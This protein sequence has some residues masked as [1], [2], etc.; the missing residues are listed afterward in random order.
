MTPPRALAAAAALAVL[1]VCAALSPSPARAE[2]ADA[3]GAAP[4]CPCPGGANAGRCLGSYATCEEACGLT[5]RGGAG[6]GG[7]AGFTPQQQMLLNGMQ[8]M[9]P[10]IQQGIHNAIYGDPAAK[11]REEAERRAREAQERRVREENERRFAEK[12]ARVLGQMD[13]GSGSLAFKDDDEPASS[14][15]APAGKLAFKDDDAPAAPAKDAK[16]RSQEFQKGYDA[17]SRCGSQNAGPACAGVSAAQT[18]KCVSDYRAGYDVGAKELK[19]ALDRAARKGAEAAG[20]GRPNGAASEPEADGDCRTQWV[21][22][23]NRAYFQ[24]AHSAKARK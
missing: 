6:G 14:A 24:A 22:A 15:S 16:P 2:Y 1:G 4:W 5:R 12:K 21:E 11:A 9:M 10:S 3:C 17:A 13:G 8:M 19:A 7:G 20:G 23:Y 18:E